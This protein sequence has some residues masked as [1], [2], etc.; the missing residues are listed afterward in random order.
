MPHLSNEDT[1]IGAQ[2]PSPMNLL[3]AEPGEN[4]EAAGMLE[5][6]RA[7]FRSFGERVSSFDLSRQIYG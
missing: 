5:R 2:T 7:M 3:L 4:A 6:C 1:M